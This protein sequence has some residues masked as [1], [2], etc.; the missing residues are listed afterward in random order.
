ME[1]YKNRFIVYPESSES[2]STEDIDS[3]EDKFEKDNFAE[4]DS[5]SD[6]SSE[7]F[8]KFFIKDNDEEDV[9]DIPMNME[10]FSLLEERIEHADKRALDAYNK[11]KDDIRFGRCD[12]DE[13]ALYNSNSERIYF[14]LENDLNNTL[15]KGSTYFHE[16]GHFID[17]KSGT[18]DGEWLSSNR[19]FK[20][21]ILS[22]VNN[23]VQK[24]MQENNCS[25]DEAYSI[26]SYELRGNRLA[27]VSDIFGSVTDCK[28]QGYWGHDREYWKIEGKMEK[29]AFANMFESSMG[30]QY[31]AEDMKKYFP[32][33]YYVFKELLEDI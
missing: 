20:G 9:Q 8:R 21:A 6:E 29:E 27:N 10:K 28:C 32:N 33:A 14:N 15:G 24:T 3:K 5:N 30:I 7:G 12:W 16:V 11:K 31:K 4:T 26:I 1:K 19:M 23:Y 2:E 18:E 13:T 17:H 25:K 22:D